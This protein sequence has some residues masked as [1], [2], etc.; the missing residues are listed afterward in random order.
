MYTG[1]GTIMNSHREHTAEPPDRESSTPRGQGEIGLFLKRWLANPLRIGAIAPAA[2]ALARRMARQTRVRDGEVVV[3]LGPGTGAVT[4]ALL[5]AGVPE[6]RLILIERDPEMHAY[7]AKHFP[8]AHLILGDAAALDSV[9]PPEWIG[10]VSTVVS[11]LPLMTLP[12]WVRDEVVRAA[13]R[14]LSPEGSLV[15]Y[16]YALFS[17]LPRKELGIAGEKVAF[18]G[19]NLPPASVWRYTR[20]EPASA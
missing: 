11:S 9:L 17:P 7:L 15:Q 10:R 19:I 3:E 18:A 5:A 20:P 13:F 16:T 8:N 1:S 12:N 2:P 6:A 4:R 14:V